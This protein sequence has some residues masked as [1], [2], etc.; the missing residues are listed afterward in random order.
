MARRGLS[1]HCDY[2]EICFTWS[3]NSRQIWDGSKS[4]KK[5][6][7]HRIYN[8][9]EFMINPGQCPSW[10][11]EMDCFCQY[12]EDGSTGRS[13]RRASNSSKPAHDP[14][15]FDLHKHTNAHSRKTA[16]LFANA[17]NGFCLIPATR[18][19]RK[20]IE[21]G[22]PENELSD[23]SNLSFTW[24]ICFAGHGRSGLTARLQQCESCT[25]GRVEISR[26]HLENSLVSTDNS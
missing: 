24:R 21:L 19:E 9:R 16:A 13:G 17:N 15:A 11:Y 12:F 6:D 7:H 18:D 1:D 26:S 2:S 14:P 3:S 20:V 23:K 5:L 25:N 22:I 10:R 8:N 4:V